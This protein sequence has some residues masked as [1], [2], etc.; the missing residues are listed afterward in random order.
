VTG[1]D[2]RSVADWPNCRAAASNTH[3]A[4]DSTGAL[5]P[6]NTPNGAAIAFRTAV[7]RFA[8][9]LTGSAAWVVDG[10]ALRAVLTLRAVVGVVDDRLAAGVR[11]DAA[12]D[13]VSV[14]GVSDREL[15]LED[16]V[17]SAFDVR[18]GVGEPESA[19]CSEPLGFLFGVSFFT[20]G[21]SATSVSSGSVESSESAVEGLVEFEGLVLVVDGFVV[22]SA[23][24]EPEDSG[25]GDVA[26]DGFADAS[27]PDDAPVPP[28]LDDDGP[29]DPVPSSA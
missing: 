6:S 27:S 28:L 12:V 2:R 10:D 25:D 1:V 4:G 11:D 16:T 18:A 29:S 23:D 9:G 14:D 8:C 24:I 20:T 26:D 19:E 17:D 3:I 22:G 15:P 21:V 7:T 13:D 5:G